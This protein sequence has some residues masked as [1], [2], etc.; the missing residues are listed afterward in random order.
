MIQHAADRVEPEHTLDVLF[1]DLQTNDFVDYVIVDRGYDSAAQHDGQWSS[2]DSTAASQGEQ[3][4][5]GR[6]GQHHQQLQRQ[7]VGTTFALTNSGGRPIR[8]TFRTI[9][10]A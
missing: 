1:S 9:C 6:Y 2:G 4:M 5:G 8:I 3:S 10:S 7:L